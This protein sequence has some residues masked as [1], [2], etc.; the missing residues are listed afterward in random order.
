MLDARPRSPRAAAGDVAPGPGRQAGA[1]EP[2]GA[3]RDDSV[4][5]SATDTDA[6]E[7]PGKSRALPPPAPVSA[8]LSCRDSEDE[9]RRLVPQD[10]EGCEGSTVDKAPSRGLSAGTRRAAP[11]CWPTSQQPPQLWQEAP[12]DG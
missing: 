11:V 6:A 3:E 4:C 12:P 2:T 9:E 7:W 10:E 1:A 8:P 5:S